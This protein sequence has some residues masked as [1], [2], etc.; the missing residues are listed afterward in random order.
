M[1]WF[2]SMQLTRYLRVLFCILTLISRFLKKDDDEKYDLHFPIQDSS[3]LRCLKPILKYSLRVSS[4]LKF[5][6]A[7]VVRAIIRLTIR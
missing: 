5:T 4:S 7:C 1:R 2:D 3:L 6:S